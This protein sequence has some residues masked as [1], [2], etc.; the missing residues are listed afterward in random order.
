VKLH[1]LVIASTS[2]KHVHSNQTKGKAKI[3]AAASIKRTFKIT[4]LPESHCHIKNNA[5]LCALERELIST[6]LI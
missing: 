4:F 6:F 5:Y 3:S 1:R 2:E